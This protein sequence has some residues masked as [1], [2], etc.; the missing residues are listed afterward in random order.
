MIEAAIPS[1][2]PDVGHRRALAAR[3]HNTDKGRATVSTFPFPAAVTRTSGWPIKASHAGR[4]GVRHPD[5]LTSAAAP[6][7]IATMRSFQPK[8]PPPRAAFAVNSP[9]ATGG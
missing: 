4:P 1:A 3:S 2:R 6:T 5:R 8:T 7:A 9:C